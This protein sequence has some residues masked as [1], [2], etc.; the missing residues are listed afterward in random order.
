MTVL[1][2]CGSE[3]DTATATEHLE[4]PPDLFATSVVP[5]E[6]HA[7]WTQGTFSVNDADGQATYE[8]P[9]VVPPGRNGMQPHLALSYRSNGADGLVG[10]GW[11]LSGLSMIT[12]CPRNLRLDGVTEG[13]FVDEPGK[14]TL[15]LDGV[16]LVEATNF[17]GGGRYRR[18]RGGSER[19]L[20]DDDDGP[21][22]SFFDVGLGL[23]RS[24]RRQRSTREQ[25]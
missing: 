1:V 13:T 11:S 18:W 8:L 15:C 21:H 5:T 19:I 24:G 22:G 17:Y 14:E 7:G 3:D 9:I 23:I 6:G 2:S 10:N 12:R 25:V 16:R 4:L 20:R